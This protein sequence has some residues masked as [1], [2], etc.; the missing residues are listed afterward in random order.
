MNPPAP[1]P[2]PLDQHR[3]RNRVEIV[4]S[5]APAAPK[6]KASKGRKKG[7]D[8]TEPAGALPARKVRRALNKAD[9]ELL[10]SLLA[11]EQDFIDSPAF[12]EESADLKIY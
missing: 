5:T 6:A 8:K 12:Y 2:S 4:E 1:T 11:Q 9:E 10:N 3:R 7:A